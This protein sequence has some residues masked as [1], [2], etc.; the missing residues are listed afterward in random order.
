[1]GD[2]P[3]FDDDSTSP[4]SPDPA[5]QSPGAW[6]PRFGI[7]AMMLL[8]FICAAMSAMGYYALNPSANGLFGNRFAFIFVTLAAPMLLL[9]LLSIGRELFRAWE[10][11]SRR[12]AGSRDQMP[13]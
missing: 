8:T 2:D 9:S 10:K 1:M 4:A 12:N 13:D 6:R 7:G 3:L 5:G 11:Q